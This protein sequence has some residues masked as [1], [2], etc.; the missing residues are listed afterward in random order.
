[1][2]TIVIHRAGFNQEVVTYS[3]SGMLNEWSYREG[4]K[5]SV[6]YV[7][8]VDQPKMVRD[9]SLSTP[10]E[11]NTL[12]KNDESKLQMRSSV[13]KKSINREKEMQNIEELVSES[14]ENTNVKPFFVWKL[15][16][17]KSPPKMRGC[18]S[19]WVNLT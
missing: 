6:L 12:K 16:T 5:D 19:G 17:V 1:M 7:T 15:E 2:G 9:P 13:L 3:D 10:T 18:V 14:L 8:L 11:C 4:R